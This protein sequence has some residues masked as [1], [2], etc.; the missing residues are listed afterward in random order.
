MQKRRRK[1]PKPKIGCLHKACAAG[2]AFLCVLALGMMLWA[3][4][5]S[6]RAGNSVSLTFPLDTASWRVSDAYGWRQDP[7]DGE[8]G[9]HQGVDLACEEGT[10]VLAAL[11]GVAAFARRSNSYGNYLRLRHGNGVETVYAHLQYLYVRAGEV[12]Q[13]GQVVGTVG[14]TGRTTGPHLHFELLRGGETCDPGAAL[15]IL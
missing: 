3:A 7:L 6:A 10:P 5:L 11:D 15:G 12:V 2:M 14:Q 9:F 4:E 1:A 8:K 13:A